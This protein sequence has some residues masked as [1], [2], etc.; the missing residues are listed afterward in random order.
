MAFLSAASFAANF[1][2]PGA[3]LAFSPLTRGFGGWV[4]LLFAAILS[5]PLASAEYEALRAFDLSSDR[6]VALLPLVNMPAIALIWRERRCF[7]WPGAGPALATGIATALPALFLAVVF[8]NAPDKSFWGHSWLHSDII[9]ALRRNA[10]APEERQLAGMVGTYPWFG[11]IFIL[12]QS[13]ALGQSP[14]QS[15][16]AINLVLAAVFGGFGLATVRAVGGGVLGSLAAPFLFAFAL[17][18]VGVTLGRIAVWLGPGVHRWAYLTGDP[19]YDFLLIKHLRL[20]LNQIGLTLV[21]GLLLLI[22]QPRPSGPEA[23]RQVALTVLLVLFVTLLYPLFMPVAVVLALSRVATDL[24]R[25]PRDIKTAAQ[26][27]GLVALVAG[28]G[29]WCVLWPLGPRSGGVGI[30]PATAGL[31]W[32]HAVM[33]AFACSLPALAA[34]WLVLRQGLTRQ[35]GDLTLLIAAAGCAALAVL[36][37]IP[38]HENEYKFVLATGLVLMPFLARALD[39]GLRHWPRPVFIPAATALFALCLFAAIN[40]VE[41]REMR[42]LDPG[43]IVTAGFYPT[44]T[45]Q[46]A[47]AIAAI[48]RQTP[49]NAVLLADDTELELS[50]LTQRAQYVPY[51]ATRAHPGMVFPN[52]YLLENVKGYDPKIVD[53]RRARLKALFDGP[54]PATRAEALRE[55]AG[56]GRPLVLMLA[57]G[58]HK[59]FSPWL[60]AHTRAEKIYADAAY[61]VWLIPARG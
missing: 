20:N 52:D 49:A 11:H 51:K 61:S 44:A 33:V 41:R 47:A 26:I 46:A 59:G 35:P 42:T 19:R 28:V 56:I 45:T 22:V 27:A 37:H 8:A 16:T 9:Y 18:P 55:V 25:P 15:F 39:E 38:N 29:A 54:G 12:I 57:K 60:A 10:F 7:G 40:S 21:A 30:A 5:I 53:G 43:Q 2:L 17:N 3:W 48:R 24:L 36:L 23:Q 14:L 1:V 6:A 31:I 50:V 34:G 58:R 13:T 32:R 4:R